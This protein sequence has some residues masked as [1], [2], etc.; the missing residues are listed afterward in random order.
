MEDEIP[1]DL[2]PRMSSRGTVSPI[3]GPAM[4]QGQGCEMNSKISIID[5]H[6]RNIIDP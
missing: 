5:I 4:Y 3:N 2:L 1:K 6:D